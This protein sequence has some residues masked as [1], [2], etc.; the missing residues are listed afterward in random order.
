MPARCAKRGFGCIASSCAVQQLAGLLTCTAPGV[1]GQSSNTILALHMPALP[2]Q[3]VNCCGAGDCLVAGALMRLMEG[4]SAADALA[5]G[6]VSLQL[7]VTIP[8]ANV[9]HTVKCR[10][11]DSAWC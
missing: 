5:H 11:A 9:L 6:M 2:A 1:T 4:S 3:V 10:E 8:D 7:P